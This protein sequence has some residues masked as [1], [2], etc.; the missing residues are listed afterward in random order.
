MD[1]IANKT[2]YFEFLTLIALRQIQQLSLLTI[3]LLST[4]D[5]VYRILE[6]LQ[7]LNI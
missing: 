6:Q 7:I 4:G 1:G 5:F 2:K 3:D